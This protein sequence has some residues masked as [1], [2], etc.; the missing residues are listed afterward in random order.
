MIQYQTLPGGDIAGKGL[1]TATLEAAS[2]SQRKCSKLGRVHTFGPC[3]FMITMQDKLEC[4]YSPIFRRLRVSICEKLEDWKMQRKKTGKQ[5]ESIRIIPL[6]VCIFLQLRLL[7]LLPIS[8]RLGYSYS[9]R[10]VASVAFQLFR[11]LTQNL[12]CILLLL[13]P[14]CWQIQKKNMESQK[15]R[16]SDVF[17]MQV[18]HRFMFPLGRKRIGQDPSNRLA[19][20]Y[21]VLFWNC[22]LLMP[23]LMS[24]P[25]EHGT[26]VEA[27]E[28]G[29]SIITRKSRA[30][31][32]WV[33]Q[34]M[35]VYCE[36]QQ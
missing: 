30:G 6:N 15:S 13:S 20:D 10:L 16:A 29:S 27:W 28:N 12:F 25:K 7:L 4:A 23:H 8:I 9:V 33:Y 31:F 14:H 22:Q 17:I 11:T 36:N 26:I 24:R 21:P 35:G 1:C 19:R 3:L 32:S 2:P 18:H 34:W 5:I